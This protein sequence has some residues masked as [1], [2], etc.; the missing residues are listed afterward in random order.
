MSKRKDS[1]F[2][3]LY[4]GSAVMLSLLGHEDLVF[5]F[6]FLSYKVITHMKK[7]KAKRLNDGEKYE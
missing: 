5:S 2:F 7:E 1:Y 3:S 4:L 6:I